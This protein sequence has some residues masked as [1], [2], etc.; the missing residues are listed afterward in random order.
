MRSVLFCN[1][2]LGLGHLR[3]SLALA[4]A[5]A[6]KRAGDTALVVTGSAGYRTMT[7]PSGVDL[8]KLPLAPVAVDPSWSPGEVEQPAALA[9][10]PDEVL[11]LR[12]ELSLAIVRAMAPEVVVVD[13][14]PLG[15]G[16]DL[17]PM[18]EWLRAST[19]ATVALGL[20]DFDDRVVMREVWSPEVV[21]AVR[22]LYDL[23]IL[24][25]EGEAG[26]PRLEA[27]DRAGVSLHRTALVGAPPAEEPPEDLPRDYLLV[28]VGGGIDGFPLLESVLDALKR[29]CFDH[30]TLFLTG[31]M[32]PAGHVA[33]LRRRAV[34]AQ[35]R[36]ER[37]RADTAAVIAGARAVVSM[38][39][40]ST[41]AELL[42]SGKPALLVPRVHPREE[43]LGRARHWAAAGRVRMLDP[44]DLDPLHLGEEV[45]RLVQQPPRRPQELSGA[46]E[47]AEI[48]TQVATPRLKP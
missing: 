2:V 12:G 22:N 10:A 3:I 26:D 29:G 46:A 43:Q 32:M 1:E 21:D 40:Y 41:V 37:E 9:M 7:L 36:V 31:P 24:Y 15:Q 44:R 6:S 14:A 35:V 5:L 30:P 18:L 33:E 11:A 8:V 48:L 4:G 47:A 25:G 34:G 45:A 42:A 27:L 39:G 28:T 13:H 19:P 38:A 23:A 20:R 17:R 16:G